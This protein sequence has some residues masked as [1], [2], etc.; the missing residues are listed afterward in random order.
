MPCE[1]SLWRGARDCA[2]ANLV[3][4]GSH[5]G[6]ESGENHESR[7]NRM[8]PIGEPA[9]LCSTRNGVT[10]HLLLPVRS[11]ATSTPATELL[12]RTPA[13]SAQRVLAPVATASR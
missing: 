7:T 12:R 4:R 2:P 5:R 8:D 11:T 3:I 1:D 9:F 10:C 6:T 13:T